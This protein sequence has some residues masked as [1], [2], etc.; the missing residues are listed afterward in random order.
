VHVLVWRVAA[1]PLILG[2]G[3]AMIVV[4]EPWMVGALAVLGL[5]ELVFSLRARSL[6]GHP[7]GRGE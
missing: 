6:A 5:A 2:M 4:A 1:R 7:S 3:Y